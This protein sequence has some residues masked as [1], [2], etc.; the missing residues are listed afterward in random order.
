MG[1]SRW[2]KSKDHYSSSKKPWGQQGL[3]PWLQGDGPAPKPLS[4]ED[5]LISKASSSIILNLQVA[6]S[7][8]W[9]MK[10]TALCASAPSWRLQSMQ[11]FFMNLVPPSFCYFFSSGPKN[12][13]SLSHYVFK[14]WSATASPLKNEVSNYGMNFK[15]SIHQ[16]SHNT[17]FR[18]SL[19]GDSP[20]KM[21]LFFAG[22]KD[23][24]GVFMVSFYRKPQCY[25]LRLWE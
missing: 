21:E 16:S 10:V 14:M 5:L 11:A 20:M 25:G 17:S 4:H 6:V 19:L 23:F 13:L 9:L 7:T 2:K 8:L 12:T 1:S 3:N 18:C 22:F 15:K 24:K